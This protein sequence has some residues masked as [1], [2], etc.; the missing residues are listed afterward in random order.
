MTHAKVKAFKTWM[1]LEENTT[2]VNLLKT[3]QHSQKRHIGPLMIR[4][5]LMQNDE[6]LKKQF[7]T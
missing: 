4:T 3:F 5:E 2:R 7:G 1:E 6:E